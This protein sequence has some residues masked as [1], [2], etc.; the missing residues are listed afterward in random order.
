MEDRDKCDSHPN[1]QI[2]LICTEAGCNF[3]PLCAMCVQNHFKH[4]IVSIDQYWKG[5]L[6]KIDFS[7]LDKEMKRDMKEPFGLEEGSILFACQDMKKFVLDWGRKLEIN[8]SR[9]ISK[10]VN[11]M[12]KMINNYEENMLNNI[13][14]NHVDLSLILKNREE[15]KKYKKKMK[16][17]LNTSNFSLIDT[18][19]K[20]L[21]KF[22]KGTK[23]IME[24][25][26]EKQKNMKSELII[27]EIKSKTEKGGR[28]LFEHINQVI[29]TQEVNL[30]ELEGIFKKVEEKKEK[31]PKREKE[32]IFQGIISASSDESLIFWDKEYKQKSTHK[33]KSGYSKLIELSSGE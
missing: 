10:D 20:D 26:K 17:A 8:T 14:E 23:D 24:K 3:Q 30:K 15:S 19:I 32:H 25:M 12:I 18:Y 29:K 33:G 11:S 1:Q 9:S 5:K 16:N 13:Q 7:Y 28:I 4:A 27:Q 21:T 31:T 2:S 22:Q 6:Q